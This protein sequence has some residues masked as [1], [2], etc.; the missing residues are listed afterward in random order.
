MDVYIERISAPNTRWRGTDG[1]RHGLRLEETDEKRSPPRGMRSRLDDPA[2][3]QS[4]SESSV[5]VTTWR[6]SMVV[7]QD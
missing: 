2:L 4:I 7:N 3:S 5:A 1:R 6:S